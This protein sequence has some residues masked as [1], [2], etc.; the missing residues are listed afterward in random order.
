MAFSDVPGGQIL[1]KSWKEGTSFDQDADF[2]YPR[3]ITPVLRGTDLQMD[4]CLGTPLT[5]CRNSEM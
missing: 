1:K 5:R 2:L 3:L 4:L